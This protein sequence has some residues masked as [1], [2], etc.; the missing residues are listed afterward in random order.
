MASKSVGEQQGE[1]LEAAWTRW[2]QDH[3]DMLERYDRQRRGRLRGAL[4]LA[5]S[6]AHNSSRRSRRAPVTAMSVKSALVT[7][8]NVPRGIGCS[9]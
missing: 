1:R 2:K 5:P 8:K 6:L 3:A 7:A 9:P 4:F